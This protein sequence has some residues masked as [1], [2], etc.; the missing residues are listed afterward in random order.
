V[1]PLSSRSITVRALR[2]TLPCMTPMYQ[3]QKNEASASPRL[4]TSRVGYLLGPTSC[5][6]ALFCPPA[7]IVSISLSN[8][9]PP[10][11]LKPPT[12]PACV[13]PTRTANRN[14]A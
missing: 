5:R 10:I 12:D 7:R 14:A 8:A 2:T 9:R 3:F 11:S 13:A 4:R 1:P 6:S